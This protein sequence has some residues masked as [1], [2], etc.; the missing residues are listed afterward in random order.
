MG[1]ADTLLLLGQCIPDTV[2]QQKLVLHLDRQCL[3]M[4]HSRQVP[5]VRPI[6]SGL[7]SP[8]K[9]RYFI[10]EAKRRDF[11]GEAKRRD[12]PN[13]DIGQFHSM[14]SSAIA[15]RVGGMVRPSAFAVFRLMTSSN[16]VGS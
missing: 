8:R 7:A 4:G 6:R 3:R 9:R 2:P 11:I 14:T 10:G 16:F 15:S 13:G 5:A 12:V 1:D